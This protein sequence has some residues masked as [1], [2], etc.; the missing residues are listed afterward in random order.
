MRRDTIFY[1]LFQQSPTLIFDFLSS[2]PVNA[3][4]Y[5]FDS[6][7]IKETS[8]RIDGVF[9]PP[10]PRG[11]IYFCEVQF[12]LDETLYERMMSEIP[13][14][15]FRHRES[16][17]DWRAVVIYPSRSV[18]QQRLETVAELLTSG[19]I[20]RVYLDELPVGEDRS[21]GL[22]LMVLTTLEGDEMVSRA[23]GLIEQAQSQ[24]DR[25]AI[26]DLVATIVVYKFTALTRDEVNAMLGIELQSTRVYQDA[27]AEGKVEGE[28]TGLER[29]RVEGVEIGKVEGER[30]L[31]LKL[32]NRKLGKVSAKLQQRV[33][34]LSIDRVEALGE[35]LLDFTSIADLESWLSHN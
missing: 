5:R 28:A 31:V 32:L 21:T 27:K 8:F 18:E 33:N 1:K 11:I 29:G 9:L 2:P 35:A 10:N 16:F 23:K 12:Q 22:D 19:R 3:S 24:P 17:F 4:Q 15:V 34:S 25:R 20:L 26:I 30:A 7:E 6:V 14:Y 13:L